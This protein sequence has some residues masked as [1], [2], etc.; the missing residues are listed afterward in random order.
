MAAADGGGQ[1]A[2][3]PCPCSVRAGLGLQADTE[4]EL[5]SLFGRTISQLLGALVCLWRTWALLCRWRFLFGGFWRP[6]QIGSC[7]EASTS[8]GTQ[9]NK[10][11]LPRH[12]WQSC[13]TNVIHLLA[14][15]LRESAIIEIGM[16]MY[17][18]PKAI[19]KS[20]SAWIV[21]A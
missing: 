1:P 11:A 9:P 5:V 6:I 16:K 2:T 19:N 7:R 10:S 21:R 12:L 20:R 8:N 18:G 14:N 3:G 13:F 15:R 4:R 17:R